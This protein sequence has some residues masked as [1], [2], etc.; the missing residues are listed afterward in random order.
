MYTFNETALIF[1]KPSQAVCFCNIFRYSTWQ[2]NHCLQLLH[3]W[4]TTESGATSLRYKFVLL[5]KLLQYFPDIWDKLCAFMS[6]TSAIYFVTQALWNILELIFSSNRNSEFCE[7]NS[8]TTY[9]HI[10]ICLTFCH[11]H[12]ILLFLLDMIFQTKQTWKL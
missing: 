9:L 12:D 7:K 10:S 5:M 8:S 6:L 2:V 1:S 11:N 4:Y 3:A